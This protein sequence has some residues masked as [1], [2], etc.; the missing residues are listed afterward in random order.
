MKNNTMSKM[1]SELIRKG[2]VIKLIEDIKND[3]S[4]PKNYATLLYIINL[5]TVMP[6]AYSIEN[7]IE[8]LRK[9][10]EDNVDCD[11]GEPCNNWVVDMVNEITERHIEIVK[12]GMGN[13]N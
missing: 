4:I 2:D 5:I 9:D 12:R 13:K 6:E 10:I 11:T 8:A 3:S 7:V 1:E